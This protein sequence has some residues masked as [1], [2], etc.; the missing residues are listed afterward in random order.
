MLFY[1][2]VLT[3]FM[4]SSFIAAD[5]SM[6]EKVVTKPKPVA[7]KASGDNL[8]VQRNCKDVSKKELLQ[9]SK[10]NLQAQQANCRWNQFNSILSILV[11]KAT[12]EGQVIILPCPL[13]LVTELNSH[14]PHAQGFKIVMLG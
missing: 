11:N 3:S 8:S 5:V 7:M 6:D 10:T 9:L 14:G 1:F 12:E 13:H 2:I 4:H